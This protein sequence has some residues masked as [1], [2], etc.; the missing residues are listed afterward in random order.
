[1]NK[2]VQ[3]I[4]FPNPP[5]PPNKGGST[6]DPVRDRQLKERKKR[7]DAHKKFLESLTSDRNRARF[8]REAAESAARS[9]RM[10][11]NQ[12]GLT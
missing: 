10:R 2:A 4:Q 8:E 9:E 1:M 6:D 11:G 12:I 5:K 3:D 7:D